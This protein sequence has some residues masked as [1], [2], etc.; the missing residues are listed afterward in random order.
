[1]RKKLGLLLMIA[2]AVLIGANIYYFWH[3]QMEMKN[4][5]AEAETVLARHQEEEKTDLAAARGQFRPN[6]GDVIGVLRIPKID[7]EL[8]ILEGT[9]DEMLEKGVGHYK[10]TAF[11]ADN[12]QILLSGH[13]DTV[14][15]NFDKLAPGDRFIVEM[16]YGTFEYMIRDT[17]IVDKDDTTIIRSMGEEVLTVST[18]YPFRF[19]GNAPQRY[20]IYAYPIEVNG[21]EPR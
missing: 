14:F 3:Q 9:E 15:T 8:P 11:P 16:P 19:V 10:T 12:E 18:C 21:D 7:K 17:E 13:R 1:M 5:L 6:E 20:I 4:A 2:G